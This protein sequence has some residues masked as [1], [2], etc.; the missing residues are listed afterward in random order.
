MNQ[1]LRVALW[2]T[3]GVA[4][5]HA[6][7]RALGNTEEEK[8]RY[9]SNLRWVGGLSA[10]G[11]SLAT[12]PKKDAVNYIFYQ[13]DKRV[14]DGITTVDRMKIR[15]KEHIRG[16]KKFTKVCYSAPKT[17][18]EALALERYRIKRFKPDFNIH[19]NL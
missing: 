16:G 14:Y 19:H 11:I 3:V 4:G 13:G 9:S 7:G 8:K 12:M 15:P 1:L 17:R 5:G 18:N 6:V 10:L 2:T